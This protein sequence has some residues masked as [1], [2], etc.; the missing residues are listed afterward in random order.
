METYRKT[1]AVETKGEGDLS[2][3][4]E[5]LR[6]AVRT[7]GMTEGLACVSVPHSTAA[8]V[9]LEFEPGLQSDIR[10]ALDRL[11]PKSVVYDHDRTWGDGNGHAHIRSSFLGTSITVPFHD[12]A[13]DL[14]TW[15]Q[16]V[17]IELDVRKR[18]R[19]VIIQIVGA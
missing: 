10:K 19:E 1:F 13:P 9:T 18:R 4:T 14:G 6:E 15:Q 8:L 5:E 3:I 7:S 12:G 16:V 2:D 17:L 11:I